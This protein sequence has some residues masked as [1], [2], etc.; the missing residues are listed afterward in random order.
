[1]S[2]SVYFDYIIRPADVSAFCIEASEQFNVWV[3]TQNKQT[4]IHSKTGEKPIDMHIWYDLYVWFV[5]SNSN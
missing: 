2:S 3:L 1:M 5:L 4:K